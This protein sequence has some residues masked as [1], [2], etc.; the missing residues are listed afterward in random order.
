MYIIAKIEVWHFGTSVC[1][2][3]DKHNTSQ[4]LGVSDLFSKHK[5]H[6]N[7]FPEWLMFLDSSC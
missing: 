1:L 3:H 7:N 4:Q 5:F 6:H 2:Y